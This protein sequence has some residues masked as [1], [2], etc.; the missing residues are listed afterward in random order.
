[1]GV[2]W[3]LRMLVRFIFRLTLITEPP[4][5][6]ELTQCIDW[7]GRVINRLTVL[8]F[9]MLIAHPLTLER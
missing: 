9:P 5:A 7:V 2:N 6:G 1:M 8:S 3:W 4:P